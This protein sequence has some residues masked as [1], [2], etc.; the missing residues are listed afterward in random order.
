[1][2]IFAYAALAGLIML[3]MRTSRYR[4]PFDL[5]PAWRGTKVTT[6]RTRTPRHRLAHTPD[7]DWVIA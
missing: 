4:R 2:I 3:I 1:M 7:R 6:H 5:A